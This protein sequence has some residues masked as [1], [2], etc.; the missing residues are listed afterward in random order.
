MNLFCL[1]ILFCFTKKHR[2]Q[3]KLSWLYLKERYICSGA[4]IL[5]IQKK[6]YHD[7]ISA[8]RQ[9][10]RWIK[11]FSSYILF[12]EL[13]FPH[14]Q[15]SRYVSKLPADML[16]CLLKAWLLDFFKPA[17]TSEG[18]R[19]ASGW[20]CYDCREFILRSS[21]RIRHTFEVPLEKIMWRN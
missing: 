3:Y 11:G 9:G 10:G 16:Y 17:V 12:W 18:G 19:G 7:N 13:C 21:F 20:G 8:G 4:L 5:L 6:R 2:I 14:H 15:K 1:G